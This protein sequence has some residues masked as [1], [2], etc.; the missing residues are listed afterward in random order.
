[1]LPDTLADGGEDVKWMPI[2]HLAKVLVELALVPRDVDLGAGG[3]AVH[4]IVHPHPVT[5]SSILP[6]IRTTIDKSGV[7][8]ARAGGVIW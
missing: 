1:M 8:T 5:W 6:V 3:A 4:H 2:D 7:A